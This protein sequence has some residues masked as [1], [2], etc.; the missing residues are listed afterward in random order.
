MAEPAKK[1]VRR[2]ARKAEPVAEKIDQAVTGLQGE[3]KAKTRNVRSR[4][5]KTADK[6]AVKL[7]DIGDAV[8]EKTDSAR[9][10]LAD[11][12]D[13]ISERLSRVADRARETAG[14]LPARVADGV[15]DR[16][17]IASDRLRGGQVGEIASDLRVK[18]QRN[19]GLFVA[20]AAAAGF[21]VAR[22]LGGRGGRRG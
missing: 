19:P 17:A 8:E 22:L 12:G 5:S 9:D 1:T 18:V 14:E 2:A 13:R 21:F 11:V 3:V 6:A 10:A 15:S 16:I 20:G 7:A 4:A